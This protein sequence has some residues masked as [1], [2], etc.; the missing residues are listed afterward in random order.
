M[1]RDPLDPSRPA[2]EPATAIRRREASPR[3]AILSFASRMGPGSRWFCQWDGTTPVASHGTTLRVHQRRPESYS[4]GSLSRRPNGVQ[5]GIDI[6]LQ[7]FVN[8]AES[9]QLGLNEE[10]SA[11]DAG[12]AVANAADAG[13]LQKFK[14]V[15]HLQQVENLHDGA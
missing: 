13:Y 5:G 10:E 12:G 3:P 7:T 2:V 1:M 8:N 11:A 9:E 15:D 4:A 14:G 6:E